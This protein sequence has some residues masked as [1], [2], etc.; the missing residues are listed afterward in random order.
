MIYALSSKNRLAFHK[1]ATAGY[2]SESSDRSG[3]VLVFVSSEG[4]VRERPPEKPMG[5]QC[6][7]MGV[8]PLVCIGIFD[9]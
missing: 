2:G 6:K 3:A 7:S 8:G 4:S 9:Y 1:G 5:R